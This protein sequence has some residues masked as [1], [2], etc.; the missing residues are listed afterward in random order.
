[1]ARRWHAVR[2]SVARTLLVLVVVGLVACR[3]PVTAGIS[4]S[5]KFLARPP[6]EQ[7]Q[8]LAE[9]AKVDAR[10]VRIDLDWS[11]VQGGGPD[12]WDWAAFDGI[13]HRAEE[14]GLQVLALPMWTPAWA[15][16]GR[17]F[18]TPPDDPATYGRFVQAASARY[19]PGGTAGTHVRA[20]EIWNEPNH[21]AFWSDAPDAAGYTRL[22]QHAYLS[23]HSADPFAT[24]ITGG[25]A[26]LWDLGQ[27][28][29]NPQHPINFL[30]AMYAAGAKGFFDAVGHHPYPPLPSSPLARPE[31][32]MGWNPFQYTATLHDVMVEHG[33]GGKQI[34]G[35]EA[36]AATG[37]CFGCVPEATQAQYLWEMYTAWKAWPWVGPL[38]WHNGRD[39]ATGS[40]RIDDNFGLVR[41]DFGPKPAQG[42]ADA[43][44]RLFDEQP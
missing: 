40:P 30:R 25:M 27:W 17:G 1:M 20:W 14:Q 22:L 4:T 41:S 11:Q 39:D 23:I 8:E 26:P 12:R 35:T 38:L 2:R 15:N 13:V 19:R 33:D 16:G 5:A 18:T 44:W 36:G 21:T 7:T 9:W 42:V 43:L 3:T 28:P 37:D 31:G 32:Y 10:W 6:A 24:V 29:E 34:W